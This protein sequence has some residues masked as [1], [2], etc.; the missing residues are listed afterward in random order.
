MH[1]ELD[2]RTVTVVLPALDEA[3]ALPAALASFPA[4]VDLVVVDNGSTDGTPEVAA[5]LGARVVPEPRRGFGAACWAG[6][7]ASPHARV[8]AFADADGSLD[9]ADL[10]AVAGP[11]L[12]QEADLVLGS[13]VRG[14]RDPGALSGLALVENVLLGLACGPLFGVRL[15]DL[16]P[17]RA[18][19]RDVLVRLGVADRGQGWP[20]EMV[21]RAALSGLRVV[22]VPVRY[23]RRAAGRS[24]VGGS[25]TGS[26]RAAAHMTA[27]A[28][29]L[30]TERAAGRLPG[31]MAGRPTDQEA[32]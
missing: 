17:F 3:A 25:L 19:R 11:V 1:S 27:V 4:G 28:G 7:Q 10:A 30:L 26:V 23:H 15:S 6:V 31:P 24:K 5:A 22:E 20:L 21:G 14:H 12:R 29:R 13:R 18:M 8:I 2:L 32:G 9:G 16:G